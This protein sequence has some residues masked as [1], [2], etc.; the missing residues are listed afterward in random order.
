MVYGELGVLPL[1]VAIDK[2]IIGYWF[3]LLCKHTSAYSYCIYRMTL[4]LFSNNQYKTYLIYKV[5]SIIDNCSSSYMWGNQSTLD[6]TICKNIMYGGI[7]DIA[8]NRWYTD[9]SVSFL[10][11]Q[12]IHFKQQL[13][14]EK[15][16][17]LPN[18]N[19]QYLYNAL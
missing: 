12:Y 6:N 19:I 15:Y 2:C 8:L 11:T 4:T 3:R 1:Q 9:A 14:F 10:C 5:K 17:L 16:L 7:N 18:N 13:C